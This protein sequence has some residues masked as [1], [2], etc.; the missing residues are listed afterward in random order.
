VPFHQFGNIKL[1]LLEDLDLSDVAVLDGEDRAALLGD[2]VSNRSRNELLDKRLEVS[3]GSELSH[4]GNHLGADCSALS[5]LGV[6]GGR[7]LVVLGSREGNAKET[8]SVSI[9]GTAVNIGLND[10]LLL[11]DERAKL[12]TGHVHAVE[13]QQTVVSL[14]ILDTKLDLAVGKGLVLL[15]IGEGDLD[16]TSLEVVR[17]DLG[18]LGLGNQG[19]SA[20][21]LGKDGR[22]DEL[23]PFFLEERIDGL[24]TGS[25]L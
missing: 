2:L 21:L 9:R 4:G 25:L 7:D 11:S 15:E 12:V 3:L 20:V 13:V 17:G 10:G 14:D 1:G 6:A 23:V 22:S 19:L 24:F 16:N 5:G 18:T 8:N